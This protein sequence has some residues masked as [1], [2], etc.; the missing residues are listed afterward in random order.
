[1][2]NTD[3]FFYSFQNSIE[4]E[5]YQSMCNEISSKNNTHKQTHKNIKTTGKFNQLHISMQIDTQ[6]IYNVLYIL[7]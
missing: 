1:V 5:I 4:M 6:S 3:S 7:K 2:L